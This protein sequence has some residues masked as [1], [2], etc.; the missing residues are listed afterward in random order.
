MQEGSCNFPF[1]I[2]QSFCAPLGEV[3]TIGN[4]AGVTAPS[5]I[6]PPPLLLPF[7]LSL[8]R[9]PPFILSAEKISK[10]SQGPIKRTPTLFSLNPSDVQNEHNPREG[11]LQG[12][13]A[14]FRLARLL[15]PYDRGPVVW[16]PLTPTKSSLTW[17]NAW[18]VRVSRLCDIPDLSISPN[19]ACRDQL[20]DSVSL[21]APLLSRP[22]RPSFQN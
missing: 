2:L 18:D 9:F 16:L 4:W 13:L 10:V 5:N 6:L 3:L 1:H 12:V 8:I 21:I 17:P 7:F 14:R 19:S 22:G 15:P 11:I 20:L